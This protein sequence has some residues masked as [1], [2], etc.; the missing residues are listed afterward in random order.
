MDD[1]F[2]LSLDVKLLRDYEIEIRNEINSLLNDVRKEN[3]FFNEMINRQEA[4][5][6][7]DIIK[8]ASAYDVDEEKSN[9]LSKIISE[10]KSICDISEKFGM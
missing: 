5:F 1:K 6:W 8:L 4:T 9:R 2:D 7:G 10:Y 3:Y